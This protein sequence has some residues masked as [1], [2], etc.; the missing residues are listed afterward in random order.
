HAGDV[1]GHAGAHGEGGF[2][3]D[4]LGDAFGAHGGARDHHHHE[5]PHHHRDEDLQEVL[6]EGGEGADLDIPGLHAVPAEPQHRGGGDLQDHHDQRHHQ[7]E[8]APH[9]D[10]DVR[11]R[12]VRAGVAVGLVILAHERAHDPDPHDL[13]TQ[14]GVDAVETFLHLPE[15]GEQEFDEDRD[16]DEQGRH[17]HPHEPREAG[18]L[19]QGH[20]HAAD[21]H[22]RGGDHEVEGEQGEHL[23]LLDVVGAAGGEGRGA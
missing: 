17:G 5:D 4:H 9:A 6:H 7:H 12:L 23:H 8:D 20:H 1:V 2:G 22:D 21:R 11:Q 15:Q 19:P 13:F 18:V 14:D 10:R 16:D 3:A